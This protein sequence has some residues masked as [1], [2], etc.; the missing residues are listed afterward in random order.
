[1]DIIRNPALAD[2]DESSDAPP[3]YTPSPSVNDGEETIEYGPHHPF[4]SAPS[5]SPW[6]VSS[7]LNVEPL[8]SH[9]RYLSDFARD[10]YA[11]GSGSNL[12]SAPVGS[13]Y[14]PPSA[15]PPGSSMSA[16]ASQSQMDSRKTGLKVT[17]TPT[18]G[19]VLSNKGRI[20][21]Y[22]EGYECRYC[23]LPYI[24]THERAS[25]DFISIILLK[26]GFYWVFR[27]QYRLPEL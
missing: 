14:R 19:C 13:P 2:L 18:P 23:A 7:H 24:N 17:F 15:P 6:S 12:S 26:C 20:L 16:S 10:F 8:A 25:A 4:Q 3:A 11:S 1:M 21:Y 9:G 5:A 22:P 27:P